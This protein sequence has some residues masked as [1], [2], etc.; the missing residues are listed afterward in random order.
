[1]R[2]ASSAAAGSPSSSR[3]QSRSQPR[4]AAAAAKP[5][6]HPP[7]LLRREARPPVAPAH[8]VEPEEDRHALLA[9][10][11]VLQQAVG[12]PRLE[13]P[14]LAPPGLLAVV[15]LERRQIAGPVPGR[16]VDVGPH[17]LAAPH[18]GHLA[19][20]VEKPAQPGGARVDVVERE[21]VPA[22]AG[23]A[24]A[25]PGQPGPPR[26]G[27]RRARPAWRSRR[28]GRR[29]GTG[30]SAPGPSSPGPAA[31]RR[32]APRRRS[33]RRPPP[34]A[35]PDA[36][37]RRRATRASDRGCRRARPALASRP[38]ATRDAPG[39]GRRWRSTSR[40][41]LATRP[42]PRGSSRTEVRR[43]KNADKGH[44]PEMARSD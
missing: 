19:Q 14:A 29:R 26:A 38:R 23:R 4:A 27:R 40:R 1:M 5:T 44:L 9:L 18:R 35:R 21:R 10:G 20:T 17:G 12:R 3:S 41:I 16:Q 15:A 22:H 33:G 2:Q 34:A 13:R 37:C 43:L 36:S 32:A 11:R 28:R 8:V 30:A 42:L 7:G 6:A 24:Q 39:R 25:A 31:A